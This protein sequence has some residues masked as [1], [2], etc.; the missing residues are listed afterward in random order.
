[1]SFKIKVHVKYDGTDFEGWQRQ[2]A[3]KPTIQAAIESAAS[4]LFAEP[5]TVVG[6]GR[7]DSGVHAQGQIAHFITSKDPKGYSVTKGLNSMLPTSISIQKAWLAPDDFHAQQKAIRKTYIYQIQNSPN[8]DPMLWRYATW[9]RR[10]INIEKLNSFTEYIIGEMDFKSFQTSGTDPKS[11][12]R[13][14]IS[15]GW[16]QDPSGLIVFEITGTGFLKQ[17]VRNIVGTLLHLEQYSEDPRDMQRILDAC[18]RQKAWGTA[19]AQGLYLH[20]VEYPQE[21]DNR[22]LEI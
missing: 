8:H 16:R 10:P 2:R 9:L 6:S 17:M 14:V 5:I 1:M 4:R 19:P 3:E 21:L 15:A 12:V 7:T 20:S 22:C 18:D 13:Q 11:T